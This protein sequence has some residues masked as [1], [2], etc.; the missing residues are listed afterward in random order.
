[1]GVSRAGTMEVPWLGQSV[2]RRED[3][4]L[5]TGRGRYVDDV[6]PEGCLHLAFARSPL[7]HGR[8]VAIDA[9]AAKAEEGVVAVFTA[10]DLGALGKNAIN[11]IVPGIAEAPFEALAR[12][13][14]TALGQPVAA[15]VATSAATARDAA[16]LVEID[17]EPLA[18]EAPG[19]GAVSTSQEVTSGDVASAF[20]AAD[21][22]VSVTVAHSLLAPTP[23]EPRATLATVA[24]GELTVWC[25]TQTPYRI[26]EDLARI[27][28]LPPERIRVIAPDVGGAFGGKASIYPEDVMVAFAAR[29]LNAPVKWVSPRSDDFLAASHGRGA[30]STAEMAFSADGRARALKAELVFQQGS[31]MTYSAAVPPNNALRILPGPYAIDALDLSARAHMTH[32]AAVGIYRGAGRPEAAILLDRLMEEGARALDIDPVEIRRRNLISAAALPLDTATGARIDSGD[33]AQLLDAVEAEAGYGRLRAAQARRRAAGEVVGIGLCLYIEPCGQ[34]WESAEAALCCNG[35]FRATT[36]ASA[37]GQGRETTFAQIAAD[38]LGTNPDL[39]DI[40]HGDTSEAE[41][42]LGALASRSTAI[43]GSAMRLACDALRGKIVERAAALLQCAPERVV[44]RAGRVYADDETG[45]SVTLADLAG[46]VLGPEGAPEDVA[47]STTEIYHAKGEAWASGCC[48]AMVAVDP[49]TGV[50]DVEK[51]VWIDDAGVV[52]NPLLAQGQMMGGLAQ[53]LGEALL[54]RLVYDDDGQLLTGSL[55]DYALP[56]AGDMPPVQIGKIE[57]RSPSNA[58]GAKGVGE[59]GCIGIPAAVFN[60]VAD[61]VSPFGANDLQM[62]LT[63]EKLWRAIR[64]TPHVATSGNGR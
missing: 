21:K 15:V 43:G 64:Q 41:R 52:V 49:D 36:G 60:A 30:T 14:V 39:I 23:L 50:L 24:D 27:L 31:W 20:E 7:A 54:E 22:V 57:T 37:Q 4:R 51:L 10:A 38:A 6:T 25:S 55:M 8:L 62:P 29:H 5:T 11:P 46:N 47:I 53:G 1:M 13:S 42:G 56:R 59:A 45:A 9:E 12:E 40:R 28:G 2:L 35:R 63:S 3:L 17:V 16:L 19:E 33:F 48:L 58:L 61:A 34:G 32:R 44:F 18:M 26:R